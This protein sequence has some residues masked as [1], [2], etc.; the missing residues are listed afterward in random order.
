MQNHFDFMTVSSSLPPVGQLQTLRFLFLATEKQWYVS[1]KNLEVLA[2]AKCP[3]G[4]KRLHSLIPADGGYYPIT[5]VSL[6]DAI[7]F[8]LHNGQPVNQNLLLTLQDRLNHKAA[9]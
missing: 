2:N 8:T 3:E 7:Q 4:V 9:A 1:L 6:D 5:L